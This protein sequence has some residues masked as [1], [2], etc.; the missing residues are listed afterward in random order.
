MGKW[1]EVEMAC[2]LMKWLEERVRIVARA[3]G[4][5]VQE[6]ERY[7]LV[8]METIQ[9]GKLDVWEGHGEE[10]VSSEEWEEDIPLRNEK[11]L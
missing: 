7:L 5:E 2:N 3:L 11:G 10:R 1:D 6:V 4:H 9:G 8:F